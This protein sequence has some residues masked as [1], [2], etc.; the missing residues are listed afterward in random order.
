MTKYIL[1]TIIIKLLIIP[2]IFKLLIIFYVF[3]N[4]KD[5]AVYQAFAHDAIIIFIIASITYISYFFK[6]KVVSLSLRIIALSIYILYLIDIIVWF[7][8]ATHLTIS[9]FYKFIDYMPKFVEQNINLNFFSIVLILF[10]LLLSIRFI[11][12]Q[13][14]IKTKSTHFVTISIL[15]TL[16]FVNL[17]ADNKFY[18]HSWIYKNFFEYNLEVQSQSRKY[19]VDFT[20][21]VQQYK[22]NQTCYE[23]NTKP[24]NTI[25]LMVESLSSYQSKLFSELNNWTPNLDEIAKNNIY[26]TNFYANGFITEHAEVAMLTGDLPIIQPYSLTKKSGNTSFNSFY[27]LEYSIPNLLKKQEIHS[28][29]I[30]SS[31]LNFSNTGIWAKSIG[32]DYIEGSEHKDYK[33]LPRYHFEA[34]EDKYLFK[35][36][37]NRIE[38]NKNKQFFLFIKTVSSHVPFINP[39]NKKHSEEE[40]IKYVDKQINIF[41]NNLK[42]NG[43]FDNGVLIIVGDHHPTAPVKSYA[44]EKFG[45]YKATAAVPAIISFGD[46][47]QKRISEQFQQTDIYNTIL[48]QTGYSYCSNEWQGYFNKTTNYSSPKFISHSRPEHRSFISVFNDNSIYN[49]HLNGDDTKIIENKEI[50]NELKDKILL[51]INYERTKDRSN[52]MIDLGLENSRNYFPRSV[53][54]QDK[55]ESDEKLNN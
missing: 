17:N 47:K 11:I 44:I 33:G 19:S 54:K 4:I 2:L 3:E 49:I 7:F 10:T 43:F 51:K 20:E 5:F 9:D 38:K 6:T 37:L 16:L 15:S 36:V 30:T 31:D 35:R 45:E 29:F 18:M 24:K 39:E 21:E 1:Q 27:N 48:A 22:E 8:Y 32:F 28:E 23:N 13:E 53:F 42:N 34:A 26:F 50:N 40:T 25:V 55:I 46:K 52:Y 12:H 41:Y 14:V